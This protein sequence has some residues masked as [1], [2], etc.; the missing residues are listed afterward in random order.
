[1]LIDRSAPMRTAPR[2]WAPVLMGLL[3][4]SGCNE[5]GISSTTV[6]RPIPVG[7]IPEPILKAAKKAV[8]GVDFREAWKNLD[9]GKTL[10][11]YEIRGR[12][13]RGK[14][15]EVRVSTTGE[16]LEME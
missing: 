10:Q 6:R 4:L 5:P 11:S 13:A 14:I 3:V 9:R 15:R 2:W 7:E 12:N 16:I 1:M 8:P